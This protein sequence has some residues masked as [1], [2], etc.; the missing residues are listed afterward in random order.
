MLTSAVR[1]VRAVPAAP[2]PPTRLWR[3]W[4]LVG[5]FVLTAIVEAAL[6]PDVAWRPAALALALLVAPTLLWR[7][8]HPLASVATAFGLVIALNVVALGAGLDEYLGLNAT[9]IM[10]VLPYA[11]VRWG[12]GLDVVLGSSVMVAAA[13]I[14]ILQDPGSTLG[15]AIGGFVVLTLAELLGLIARL[16]AT[17]QV[18]DR[19]EVRLRERELL[20]RELHDTVA[21]HI[22]AI[23]VRA[24]AGQVVAA[25]RPDAAAEALGV[26]EDEAART[27]AEL[28]SLVGALRE[29]EDADLAPQPGVSELGRLARTTTAGPVVEV[30]VS[31]R[32]D[33]LPATTGTAVYRIA[34]ESVTNALRHARR[35]TRVSVRMVGED[36]GVRLTVIDDGGPSVGTAPAGYGLVG[37]AERAALLGGTFVAG[38]EPERGWA[39][40]AWLPRTRSE[41]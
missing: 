35:A 24:Q 39:V 22:T 29:S 5:A 37:M 36:D 6:R 26:I 11:L 10:L 1:A 21:H 9:A 2:D 33:D 31:G 4:L 20:A 23:V 19:D 28:R 8:T 30:E 41:P 13:V 3:D 15:D 18:R 38:P 7:R 17:A 40:R 27:L 25:T 32:V 16:V 12:S 34:Q 14:G